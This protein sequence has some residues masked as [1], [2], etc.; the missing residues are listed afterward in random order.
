MREFNATKQQVF[1]AILTAANELKWNI[2]DLTEHTKVTVKSPQSLMYNS[3]LYTLILMGDDTCKVS[4]SID[5]VKVGVMTT[6]PNKRLGESQMNQLYLLIE[7]LLPGGSNEG[8]DSDEGQ[9]GSQDSIRGSEEHNEPEN[10]FA[11]EV[12][13][14]SLQNKRKAEDA[15]KRIAEQQRRDQSQGYKNLGYVFLGLLLLLSAF[16]LFSGGDSTG[17]SGSQE[18]SSAYPEGVQPACFCSSVLNGAGVYDYDSN[19]LNRCKRMYKC[20]WNA[21]VD[22]QSGT[23]TQWYECA[24]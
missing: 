12:K 7:A 24:E 17:S 9:V 8:N 2:T 5:G 1:E 20:G 21:T 16:Y 23:E 22:C 19:Q 14:N 6:M 3:Q 18:S 13:G 15:M 10:S 4:Y 11:G